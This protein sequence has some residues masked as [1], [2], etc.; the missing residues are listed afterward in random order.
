MKPFV[1]A[2][3]TKFGF[4]RNIARVIIYGQYKYGGFNFV[5]LWLEQGILGVKYLLG[6]LKENSVVSKSIMVALSYAQLI[7]GISIQYMKD[8]TADLSYVPATWLGGMREFL[9]QC[10]SN[11]NIANSWTPQPQ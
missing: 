11:L 3:I 9:A 8:V 5:H 10:D 6:H 2:I 4:N 1:R 7:S